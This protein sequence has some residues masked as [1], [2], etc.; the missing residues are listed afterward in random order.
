MLQKQQ[1]NINFAKGLDTKTDPNQ[2]AIGNFLTLQN[3]IF[4]KGGRL[5]KRN[6]FSLLTTLPNTLQTTLTTFDNSLVATGSNL[7]AFSQDTDQWLGAGI[8]QP[9]SLTTVSLVKNSYSQ[10]NVCSS[11]ASNNLVCVVYEQNGSYGYTI[12]DSITGQHIY[13]GTNMPSSASQ[14]RAYALDSY[15]I[16]TY[17]STATGG[18]DL[19][20]IAIPIATPTAPMSPATVSIDVESTT[21]GYDAYVYNNTLYL[22][23]AGTTN[24]INATYL[25]NYL[26]LYNNLTIATISGGVFPFMSV[27]A[28]SSNSAVWITAYNSNSNEMVTY[29]YDL[30]LAVL[31]ASTGN[32]SPG[33]TDAVQR[34]TSSVYNSG[35]AVLIEAKET[36]STPSSFTTNYINGCTV[37]QNG[38]TNAP[39]STIIRSLGLASKAFTQN[40]TVYYLAAYGQ[41]VN[42]P[43]YFLVDSNA[44]I[45]MKLAYSN[46]GGY[47]NSQ[48]L[49]EITNV[50]GNYN[51]VYLYADFLAT[52][53]KNTNVVANTN[54]NSIYTQQGINLAQFDINT[55][56]QY[57]ANISSNLLL[58][59]GITWSYDG[60]TVVEQGFN[61][62]PDYVYGTTTGSGGSIGAGTYYYV[63]TYEWTDNQGNLYRSA[64]SIPYEITV[65]SGSST[66]TLYVG[67]L[68]TTYKGGVKIVGYRWSVAQQTYYQFTSVTSPY[69]NDK[70][71]DYIT[72]TDTLADSSILGNVLL[73]TT[74]G[75]VEDIGA[76]PSSLLTLYNDRVFVVDAEDQNLLWFSKQVIE[77]TPVE[78]SD[79]F[80]IYVAPTYG[81]QGS[82]GSIT[83]LS[84]MDDK[85][86]IFKKDAIYYITGIGPDNTG[87]NNDF[88]NPVFVTA[89]VGCSNPNSIVLMPSGI[90]FQSD[91]GIWLLG[92]DLT[93][94]YIG[95][96][97]EQFN[98]NTVQ[99]AQIIPA[100]NQVRFVLNNST[101][102]MYDY[103]YN[104]WGT[105]TN[106]SAISSTLYQGFQTY[107][108]SFG[109]V[110]QETAG[111]YT[112]NTTPVLMAFTTSWISAAGLQGYERF[113]WL[114]LLGSYYTPFKLNVQFAYDYNPS[115]SQ[116][117]LVTPDN[118]SPPWGGDQL[119][120]DEGLWGGPASPFQ[121]RVFPEK[122]K[123][124][125]FQ[126]SMTEIYDPTY[127][128]MTGAGL[129][130]SGLNLTIGV[131]RGSRTQSAAKSFG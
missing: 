97:V 87:A 117:V 29:I 116:N 77:D 118:Y 100:T 69:Y 91:K 112:D 85:L 12:S 28:N 76:P 13:I 67:T 32:Y 92:R 14:A 126:L 107:L 84:P 86:V 39:A 120:G 8:V 59:G 104:Q 3:S 25:T 4:D 75:V 74:G 41:T 96:P 72:I 31:Q 98:S 73:Y 2:V 20:Y 88:S 58:T 114:N 48:V 129:S 49:P 71:V 35:L 62:W 83:A 65:G 30:S 40:N 102:L 38:T 34:I 70:T 119:W 123:C 125:T 24:N 36:Y 80:T 90:M 21:S 6:G 5:T 89:S 27:T 19:Q 115:P 45:I 111:V 9:V 122:Q 78:F 95:A 109:Q 53:N 22:C 26:N 103:F 101:T 63:F 11:T 57:N 16:V 94:V 60:T 7:Y 66:N 131:K 33:T 44:N 37:F 61:L 127:G 105:F 46:G 110:L 17:L 1:V 43:T 130:L 81:A 18:P 79:L 42:Q 128:V 99:S 23:W 52:V 121:A 106:N 54:I 93:T 51:V 68:R 124:Q 113:Y 50:N 15:F 55:T 108:N 82:T 56:G 47:L 64:P 10:S